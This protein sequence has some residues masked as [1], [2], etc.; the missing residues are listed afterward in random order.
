MS[1]K[2]ISPSPLE[3]PP[4]QTVRPR[5]P[6]APSLKVS[7]P[8]A[9]ATFPSTHEN[10]PE[11][12]TMQLLTFEAIGSEPAKATLMRKVDSVEWVTTM[13]EGQPYFIT[14][15]SNIHPV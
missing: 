5:A 6:A 10:D 11:C 9:P 3:L 15:Y 12:V 2:T 7:I 1:D 8:E 14:L 4:A 13:V